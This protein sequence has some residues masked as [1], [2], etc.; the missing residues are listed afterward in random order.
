[1]LIVSFGANMGLGIEIFNRYEE[2]SFRPI[3]SRKWVKSVAYP[4]DQDT[5][6]KRRFVDDKN[7]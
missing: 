3:F 7:G 4:L 1:M 2:T 6:G 5:M